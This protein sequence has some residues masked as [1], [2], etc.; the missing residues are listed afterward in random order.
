MRP[1]K[2]SRIAALLA[3]GLALGSCTSVERYYLDH[4]DTKYLVLREVTRSVPS[5]SGPKL[6][7]VEEISIPGPAGGIP[8][9]VYWPL[10]LRPEAPLVLYIHGGG[11]AI[12]SYKEMDK[13]TRLLA[14][15][16]E[17]VVVSIDYA[18][19]PEHPYP[20]GLADCEAAF[21][22][23]EAR[24]SDY[25]CS[26]GRIVVSGD[27]AGGNLS[28]VLCQKRRDEGKSMP[29]AQMLFSPEVGGI[30]PATGRTWP[31]R[32]ENAAK[33]K[34]TPHS[35][36]AFSKLYLGDPEKYA[37]DPYVNP[38]MAKS[39]ARLPRTLVVSCGLDPLRDEAEAYARML[40]EAGAEVLAKRFEG[41]DHAYMGKE[42]MALAAEF[43]MSL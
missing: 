32:E 7:K 14:A 39:F 23:L 30:D 15:G 1:H 22:W 42:V 29:L 25:R 4:I 21:E 10:K 43:L 26:P 12:G 2:A 18:L 8:A 31:S 38:I 24:A 40:E 35:L 34:L 17:C 19:A 28:A 3:I 5:V 9:R 36:T 33:S 37:A 41:K 13:E 11:Y 20:A 6:A 27:S 16:G